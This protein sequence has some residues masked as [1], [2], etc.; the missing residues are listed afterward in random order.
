MRIARSGG[1]VLGVRGSGSVHRPVFSGRRRPRLA[2]ATDG[3]DPDV[4]SVSARWRAA[5][6]AARARSGP[7]NARRVAYPAFRC[8]LRPPALTLWPRKCARNLERPQRLP[9]RQRSH[10]RASRSSRGADAA[11]AIRP[12]SPSS[13]AANAAPAPDD[14][15]GGEEHEPESARP[16]LADVRAARALRREEAGEVEAWGQKETDRGPYII[17]LNLQHVG[18]LTGAALRCGR[19]MQRSPATTSH[20]WCRSRKPTCGAIDRPRNGSA[21]W[22]RTTSERP[23]WRRPLATLDGPGGDADAV[24]RHLQAVAGLPVLRAYLPVDADHQGRRGA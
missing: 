18:G 14:I 15:P 10:A 19:S 12:A 16:L 8:V 2:P 3:R 5:R 20:H 23:P 21:C 9:I 24:P 17:E 1:R 6:T 7:K 22:K 13:T 4:P 11:L